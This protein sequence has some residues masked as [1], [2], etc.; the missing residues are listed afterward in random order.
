MLHWNQVSIENTVV[1][2]LVSVAS[3]LTTLVQLGLC[4][5]PMEPAD[6]GRVTALSAVTRTGTVL[7]F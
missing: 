7:L 3:H 2:L 6:V 1:K 4:L 5:V